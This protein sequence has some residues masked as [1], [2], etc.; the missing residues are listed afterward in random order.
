MTSRSIRLLGWLGVLACLMVLSASQ[1]AAVELPTRQVDVGV[2]ESTSSEVPI[3]QGATALTV[4]SV[5]FETPY[6]VE[7]T[8]LLPARS[9]LLAL[10]PLHAR[11]RK[12][13]AKKRG[14]GKQEKE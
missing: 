3:P 2:M 12:V 8:G 9:V 6:R 4:P 13:V 7:L 10:E 5:D 11:S 1:V 14:R